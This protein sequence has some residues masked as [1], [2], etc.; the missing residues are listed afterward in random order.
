MQK[1]ARWGRAGGHPEHFCR[2]GNPSTKEDNI[3]TKRLLRTT[4][5]IAAV[6]AV[7]VCFSST[8]SA[9]IG[10]A[11]GVWPL[12]NSNHL[13]TGPIDVFA[14][15]WKDGVTDPAGQGADI[16]A[17]LFYTPEGGAQQSVAMTYNGDIGNNDEYTAQVP[18]AA[19][20]GVSFVDV[21]V[22]FTDQ[23]DGST[24]EITGDQNGNPPPLRYNVTNALPNDVDVTF[25]L[26]MSGTETIGVPCVIGSAAEIGSWGTG[27]NMGPEGSHAEL[28]TITVTF[29]AGGNP[30]FA[31]KYKKDDCVDWE[32][33]G[34]R[35]VSLPT[36][37]TTSVV[38]APDS[39]NN[40]PIGCN[41]SE[42]L[43]EDKNVCFQ[44]CLNGS[45][46]SG[47]ICVTGSPGELTG[48]GNG[49]LMTETAGIYEV[50]VLF[51]AGTPVQDVEYKFRKDGCETWENVPN[52]IVT[53][54]NSSPTEQ[55]VTHVWDIEGPGVC[56]PI[57]TDTVTW[58]KVKSLYR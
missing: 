25:T 24:F 23:T 9:T 55:T 31:Y 17:E 10:W 26:C 43:S 28:W 35:L 6:M 7:I 38:L 11:G 1:S 32:S 46:T 37:G 57:S 22:I 45:E 48:W 19:L 4:F 3:M 30:D 33:V 16:T 27:V 21:T 42:T 56:E 44:V 18:Q 34:D 8:A 51:V 50:C 20:L 58:G 36:D 41:L 53:V 15:V 49:V 40:A 2:S 39:W 47:D 14:Q 54:D 5:A 12:H 13:P 29:L 52:R